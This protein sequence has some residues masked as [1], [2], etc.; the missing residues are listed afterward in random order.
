MLEIQLGKN[1]TVSSG[2]GDLFI[3][4][5]WDGGWEVNLGPEQ[6]LLHLFS[7]PPPV[8][9]LSWPAIISPSHPSAECCDSVDWWVDLQPLPW[10]SVIE[11]PKVKTIASFIG[12]AILWLLFKCV[13]GSYSGIVLDSDFG[14][15]WDSK[16]GPV[17]RA[18]INFRTQILY[19]LPISLV[20]FSITVPELWTHAGRAVLCSLHLLR[21]EPTFW[22]RPSFWF[23]LNPFD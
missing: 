4:K 14:I 2:F 12:V 16:T 11:S 6:L 22:F 21:P 8:L 15:T 20:V 3:L 9:H 18:F 17:G 5:V 13:Q 1:A 7:P 23:S 10:F 19:F